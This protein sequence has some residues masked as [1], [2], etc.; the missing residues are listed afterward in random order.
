MPVTPSVTVTVGAKTL[1]EGVDYTVSYQ[2]N[3]GVG[4]GMAVVSGKGAYKGVAYITFDIVLPAQPS[5]FND[6]NKGAW[7]YDAVTKAAERGLM[8]GYEAKPGQKSNFGPDDMLTR[9]QAA[10]IFARVA[11]A[12]LNDKAVNK[13]PFNDVA[14]GVYYTDAINWAYANKVMNGVGPDYTRVNPDAPITRQELIVMTHN[15]AKMRGVDVSASNSSFLQ[16]ADWR[17]VDTWAVEAMVWATDKGVLNGYDLGNGT[18][19]IGAADNSTRAQMA[20]FVVAL[21]DSV[22]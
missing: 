8:T 17:S 10:V 15:F 3:N 2:N 6:V 14:N 11:G 16:K 20:A 1:V 7:Y 4:K 9:G 19:A 21:V 12:D 13:T 18:F 5:T 22:L